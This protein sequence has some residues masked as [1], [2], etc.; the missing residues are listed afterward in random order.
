MLWRRTYAHVA[1]EEEDRLAQTWLGWGRAITSLYPDPNRRRQLYKTSFPPRSGT[2]L[3]DRVDEIRT[4][5]QAGSDYAD[6]TPE[7]QFQF[8][9]SVI[10]L[11]GEVPAFRVS[12]KLGRMRKPFVD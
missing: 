4:I 7:Q 2:I 8:V 3:L 11:L 12:T 1:A 6:R 5:L 10:A 9:R